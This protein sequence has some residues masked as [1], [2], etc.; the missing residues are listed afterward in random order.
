[1]DEEFS[2]GSLNEWWDYIERME[3][4]NNEVDDLIAV[5]SAFVALKCAVD[6]HIYESPQIPVQ[7]IK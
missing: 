4:K 3:V 1:V 6:A 2:K 7:S 5:S